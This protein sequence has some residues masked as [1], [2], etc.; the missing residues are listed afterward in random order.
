M[1]T[2]RADRDRKWLAP[3]VEDNREVRF[4]HGKPRIYEPEEELGVI[5][6]HALRRALRHPASGGRRVL[7]RAAAGAE[8]RQRERDRIEVAR[9][10]ENDDK[11]IREHRLSVDA[12]ETRLIGGRAQL[13]GA[14]PHR[15]P[16]PPKARRAEDRRARLLPAAARRQGVKVTIQPVALDGTRRRWSRP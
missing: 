8:L 15:L 12:A 7:R 1:A 5:V 9:L 6:V 4:E 16:P 14:F 13:G 3:D 10:D 2:T 11:N